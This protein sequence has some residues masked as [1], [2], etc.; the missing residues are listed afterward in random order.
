MRRELFQVF[1]EIYIS[2]QYFRFHT[3][4]L[5]QV[6]STTGHK[7]YKMKLTREEIDNPHKPKTWNTY[8]EDFAIELIFKDIN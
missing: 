6:P 4:F 7:T 8:H 5:E 2:S 3:A 1:L